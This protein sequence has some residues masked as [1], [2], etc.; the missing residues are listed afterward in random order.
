MRS[1][2]AELR[3]A[4]DVSGGIQAD[5]VAPASTSSTGIPCSASIA[6]SRYTPAPVTI[7]EHGSRTDS[8]EGAA[9]LDTAGA[10][11]P[12]GVPFAG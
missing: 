5:G 7:P 10:A 4:P 2:P 6:I 12:E 9:P 8:A 11:G 3:P 1:R